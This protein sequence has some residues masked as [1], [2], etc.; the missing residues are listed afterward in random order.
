MMEELQKRPFV[1]PLLFWITG[2]LL[3]V[4][5]PLQRLS[6]W[7]LL[8]IPVVWVLSFCFYK[9]DAP[10]LYHTRWIWGVLFA[11]FMIFLSIQTTAYAERHLYDSRNV[12][13]LQQ[14]ARAVQVRMVHKLDDLRLSEEEKSILA[15]ITISYHQTLSRDVRQKFSISGASHILVVSGFHVGILYGFLSFLFSAFPKRKLF[16]WVKVIP[17]LLSLWVFAFIAGLGVSTVRATLMSSLALSGQLFRRRSERYNTLASAAFL[18]LIYNPFNLFNIGFQLSFIAVFFIFWLQ[19][20]LSRLIDVRNPLLAAPWDAMTVTMAAQIG[21]WFLC[22]Y[23]FGTVSL[24]ALMSSFFLT[25][26]AIALIPLTLTWMILPEGMPWSGL[27]QWVIEHLMH[28]FE[29]F[30]ERF[31][32]VPGAALSLRFDFVTLICSYVFLVFLVNYFLHRQARM[33]IASLIVLQGILCRQLFACAIVFRSGIARI[34][35]ACFGV[36]DLDSCVP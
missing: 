9:K 2:I 34:E 32:M 20:P 12:S 3:Q 23:Y 8:P 30:V 15:A 1:R 13:W 11:C 28:S 19:P 10:P 26:L 21:T 33:L 35:P 27:L 22:C 7:L 24:I 29:W 25:Y 6:V 36:A 17:I 14:Q 16:R 18:L 4:C 5:Y 31:S